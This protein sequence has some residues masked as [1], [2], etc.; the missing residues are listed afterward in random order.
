MAERSPIPKPATEPM[1][2]A[3]CALLSE[4]RREHETLLTLSER[5]REAVAHARH[6]E[7]SS[8]IREES[9]VAQRIASIERR[10]EPV[11]H[12]LVGAI[13]GPPAGAPRGWRAD[14][15]WIAAR[16]DERGA[17]RLRAR[18]REVREIITELRT[19][20]ASVA[21]AAETLARHLQGIIRTVDQRLNASGAYTPRGVAAA[22]PST[23]CGVDITS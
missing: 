19:R 21:Q 13:G 1:L 18:A 14:S 22:A 12:A 6:A 16:L 7:L 10:R 9:E 23:L 8:C 15:E 3:L 11:V 5:K 2:D 20:N 17:E 4:L